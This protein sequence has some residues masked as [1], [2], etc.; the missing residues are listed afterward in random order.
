L[1]HIHTYTVPQYGDYPDDQMTEAS[2]ADIKHDMQRYLNRMLS[3]ARGQVEIERDMLKLA[4]YAC[5][6]YAKITN[7]EGGTR[8]GRGESAEDPT[9]H[10]VNSPGK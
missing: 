1:D 3:N 9:T 6:A 2:L 7:T 10:V 8:A 5:I 4:H